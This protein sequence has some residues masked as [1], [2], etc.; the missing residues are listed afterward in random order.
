[1]SGLCSCQTRCVFI[2]RSTKFD[3][4]EYRIMEQFCSPVDDEDMRDDLCNAIHS[5]NDPIPRPELSGVYHDRWHKTESGWHIT[6]RT[7][8]HDHQK[9]YLSQ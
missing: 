4:H 8:R 9:R 1:M 6:Q 5:G 2:A 3:I 7:L